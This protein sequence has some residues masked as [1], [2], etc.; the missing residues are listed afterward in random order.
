MLPRFAT[1]QGSSVTDELVLAGY[2]L[3]ITAHSRFRP[4]NAGYSLLPCLLPVTL[5][6]GFYGHNP[7]AYCYTRKDLPQRILVPRLRAAQSSQNET[8][9][10]CLM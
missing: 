8:D 3:E 4:V 5:Q 10:Y 2:A 1:P 7:A 6:N 9:D